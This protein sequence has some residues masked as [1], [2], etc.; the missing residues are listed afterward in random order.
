MA[1]HG[2]PWLYSQGR[3]LH[4]AHVATALGALGADALEAS[5]S[6]DAHGSPGA[7][8]LGAHTLINI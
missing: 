7:Q 6:V 2:W 5:S 4:V 3:R 8:V 1:N